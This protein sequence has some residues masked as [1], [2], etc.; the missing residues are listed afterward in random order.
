LEGVNLAEQVV[1]GMQIVVDAEGSQV[2]YAGQEAAS[3][4]Q[5]T[6]GGSGSEGSSGSGSSGG[7][8]GADGAATGLINLNTADMT[9]LTTLSGVGPAT[10]EAIIS[11]RETNGQFATVEQLMEVRGIGP[12]KFEA[13]RDSV[14]V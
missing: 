7:N 1:D 14:T 9:A 13:M 8:G 2:V 12:A 10:A 3:P 5:G 4:P 11:W 6:A